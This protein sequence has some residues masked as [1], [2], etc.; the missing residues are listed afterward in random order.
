MSGPLDEHY[1]YLADRVKVERYKAAIERAVR[2]GQLVMD[3]GCGSGLLGLIALYA[4][5]DKVLF[6]EKDPIIGVAR[7]TVIEAGFGE[8]ADFYHT[9]SYELRLIDRV[10]VIICDHVGY[11][12]IDYG[13]LAL[14]ADAR[15]RFLDHKGMIVPARIDLMLA[16]AETAIGRELVSRWTNGSISPDYAWVGAPAANYKYGVHLDS[17][18]LL[19]APGA[20][21][22]LELGE[23][24]EEFLRWQTDFE[25]SRD[26]KLD[27]LLGWFDCRLFADIHMTNSPT[28]DDRLDRP[29]R[30]HKGEKIRTSVMARPADHILA[31]TIELQERGEQYSL[32]TFNGLLLDDETLEH[33]HPDRVARLNDR[34]KALRIV[35]S[36]CDGVRT[37]AE[38]EAK[39]RKEHPDLFLSA[40]E[41]TQL[42]QQGLAW[43]TKG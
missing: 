11:F 7:R 5:A 34:G 31:W 36:Y 20:L 23:K 14:L 3:L 18:S 30:V 9:S 21:A 38:V 41:A 24:A 16:P 8:R 22:T 25:C 40:R 6:V 28:A 27:G 39:V 4:G 33:S 15:H 1:C 19:A 17:D 43:N 32:S 35:L 42:I 26:G 29:V 13:I 37:V 12:G 2:P 10:D